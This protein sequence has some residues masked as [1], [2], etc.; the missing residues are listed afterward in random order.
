MSRIIPAALLA[1]HCGVLLTFLPAIASA[2]VSVRP[3]DEI[4]VTARKREENLQAVPVAI[5]VFDSEQLQ[6]R[7]IFN[8]ERLADQTPGL[9]FATNGSLTS[10]RAVIRGVSQ[11]TRVG[12]ETNV[13]TFIDGVYTPG[14]TGAEYFGFD[15]LERVEVVKGPQS[16]IYGRNSFAG[17]INY[18]TKKP[19]FDFDYGGRLTLGEGD[20]EGLSG[21]ITGPVVGDSLALRLDA[22]YNKSGGSFDN[23]VDGNPLGSAET[24]F[25]RIGLNWKATDRLSFLGSLSYQDDFIN[26]V[27]AT[28]VADDDPNRIGKKLIFNYSPFENSAGGGGPIGRLFSGGINRTSDVYRIDPRAF[29]GDRQVTRATLQFNY[30]F[31]NFELVGLTGYQERKVETLN[32][33]NTCRTD[34]R[35]AVC[36]IVSPTAVGTYF[37][38]PL[39]GS[40]QI[41]GV[42]T[43]AIE[44]RDEFSQDLRLQSTGD[45]ALEWAVGLYYSTEDFLDQNRRLS[46]SALTN[47]GATTIYATA[48]TFPLVDATNLISNDFYSVY[49]SL[50][51]DFADRWNVLLELRHTREEK[52]ANQVSNNF[53][54]TTPPTGFQ[55]DDFSFTTPR[56]ILSFD[57]TEDWLLYASAAKGVKSGGFNPGSVQISTYDQEENWSYELGSKLTFWDGKARVNAAAY[58][59]DW[60]DQQITA[61]DPDNSRLPITTNVA[62]SEIK[63]FELEAFLNPSDWLQFNAGFTILEA[64]YK[65]GETTSIQFLTDCDVLPIPC[66]LD[67]TLGLVTSG[68]VAGQK[69]VGTPEASYNLG[70]QV[71][72][73]VGSGGWEFLGRADYSW[74]DKV[75]IDQANAGY[76]PERR[77]L[78]L[79]LGI[80]NSHW[81]LQSFC[82]NLTDDDTPI[83]ALPPRDILGVPHYFVVNRD[84]RM[85]GLDAT[86]RY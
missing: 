56:F 30:D 60:E 75:Y 78:N 57:A 26:P 48:S 70:A 32:D 6:V 2:Q 50:G 37:G 12:D 79:R 58:F 7:D 52:Q 16:A 5:S 71:N 44:D 53:P 65:E 85:C 46:D 35:A 38:G 66:D 74:Q 43:G 64:E 4:T 9:S 18:V 61:T 80:N 62:K 40:R 34:I 51:Y 13:S 15:S 3:V 81:S 68:N 83:F 24:S 11:Q 67:T 41:I 72:L 84:G 47:S 19:D 69:I 8:L 1:V 86:Y 59:I 14:F 55:E 25:A 28:L 39:A 63:G 10:R 36:D 21:Y 45:G 33:Y 29:A 22:G 20:R 42:L 49:G 76:I 77:T 27:P 82:N 23:S 73:P 31:E 17:A 54:S